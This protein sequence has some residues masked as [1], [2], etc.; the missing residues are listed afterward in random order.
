MTAYENNIFINLYNI[1][2]VPVME[3]EDYLPKCVIRVS[4]IE[5][6]IEE[7]CT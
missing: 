1:L 6:E 2:N 5:L 3:K 7:Y 4:S